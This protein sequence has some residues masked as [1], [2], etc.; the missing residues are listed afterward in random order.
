MSQQDLVVPPLSRMD[1]RRRALI[2]RQMF[3]ADK[4]MYLAYTP[5]D[6]HY[7]RMVK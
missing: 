6:G 3:G 2:F 7:K 5:F 4:I 1:I